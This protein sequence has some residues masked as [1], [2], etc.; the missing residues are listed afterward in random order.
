MAPADVTM[1]EYI[2]KLVVL[3]MIYGSFL[4][5]SYMAHNRFPFPIPAGMKGAEIGSSYAN[6]LWQHYRSTYVQKIKDH[7]QKFV[8][9]MNGE[10]ELG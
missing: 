5:N 3:D 4:H 10:Q 8:P 1:S 6:N 9:N 2:E 7:E